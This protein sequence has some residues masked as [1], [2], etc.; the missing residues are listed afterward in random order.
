MALELDH[1]A[2][3]A[4]NYWTLTQ[5][6]ATRLDTLDDYLS[7][8]SGADH[9]E[10]WTDAALASDPR[11]EEVRTQAAAALAAFGWPKE[12]PPPERYLDE[13]Q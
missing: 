8:L 9:A 4:P 3:A 6:Q 11:W 12:A 2:H 5:E 7:A 1:W 10:F 13:S